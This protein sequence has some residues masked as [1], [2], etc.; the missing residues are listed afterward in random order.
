VWK[1]TNV[2]EKEQVQGVD[3]EDEETY[4]PKVQRATVQL[5]IALL[6]EINI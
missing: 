2:N 5:F 3:Y 4:A 6:I 1:A